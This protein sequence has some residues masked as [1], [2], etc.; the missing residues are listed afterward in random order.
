MYRHDP[1]DELIR[2]ARD[3]VAE[4]DRLVRSRE[5]LVRELAAAQDAVGELS[6]R[7][8]RERADVDRIANAGFLFEL[9]FD[10]DARLSKEQHAL[11]RAAAEHGEAVSLR[12]GLRGQLAALDQR[13]AELAGSDAVLADA[14]VAKRRAIA[15]TPSGTQ[16]AAITEQ[17]AA[18]RARLPAFDDAI[19]AGERARAELGSLVVILKNASEEASRESPRYEHLANAGGRMGRVQAELNAFERTLA[20]VG[21]PLEV[22]L[23]TIPEHPTSWWDRIWTPAEQEHAIQ[24]R[25]VSAL[26]AMYAVLARVDLLLI[27]ARGHCAAVYR[28][29]AELEE[30]AA[31]LVEP[32]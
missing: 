5:A 26:T 22:H 6:E 2:V 12:D 4:R 11:A 8:V 20:E 9:I 1:A 30:M 18:N 16:L 29:T 31:Q 15:A 10:R 32:M 19:A 28:Q 23:A 27:R 24:M 13:L 14:R 7:L 17:L 25:V 21:I 3:A